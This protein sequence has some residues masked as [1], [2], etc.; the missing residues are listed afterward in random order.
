MNL[1]VA[2]SISLHSLSVNWPTAKG[3]VCLSVVSAESVNGFKSRLD[4]G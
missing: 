3:I 2:D 1:K 4:K